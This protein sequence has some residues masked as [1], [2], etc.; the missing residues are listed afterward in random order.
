VALNAA[1]GPLIPVRSIIGHTLTLNWHT[2][3]RLL[4]DGA[5]SV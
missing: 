1:P 3:G 2:D 5:Q 4:A